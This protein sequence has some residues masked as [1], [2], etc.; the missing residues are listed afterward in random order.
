MHSEYLKN[1]FGRYVEKTRYKAQVA[2]RR[3][4]LA[5]L[6]QTA[7]DL[8]GI[9][10]TNGGVCLTSKSLKHLFDKKPAEEFLF[11]IDHL[12]DIVKYPSRI[13]KNKDNRRGQYCLV[14]EVDGDEYLCA[15]EVVDTSDNEVF[16]PTAFRLRDERYLCNYT[17]LWDWGNGGPHRHAMDK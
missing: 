6:D 1:F 4:F 2:N 11:L 17:L 10:Y 9:E 15:I 7:T 12:Y 16:I 13:Y 14:T 3:L 8:F 5:Q